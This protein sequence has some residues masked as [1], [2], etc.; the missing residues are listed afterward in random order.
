MSLVQIRSNPN[1]TFDVVVRESDKY[2][3][4]VYL[5]FERNTD[6]D[7]QG[8]DEVFMTPAQLDQ[9]GRFLIRQASEIISIQENRK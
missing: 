2:S 8:C 4:S 9:L 1:F 5:K 7:I 6:G 3:E